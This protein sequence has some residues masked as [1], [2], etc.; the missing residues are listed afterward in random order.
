[1]YYI[2]DTSVWVAY[3]L[4]Q[5]SCHLRAKSIIAKVIS[6]NKSDFAKNLFM[7]AE[8][9]IETVNTIKRQSNKS[10]AKEFLV[11]VDTA[12][13]ISTMPMNVADCFEKASTWYLEQEGS[14]SMN[15]LLLVSMA[16]FHDIELLTFDKKLYSFY[17]A[18]LNDMI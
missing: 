10:V 18:K 12:S 2:L 3:F 14:L 1:M 16:I 15:D 7:P 4:E 11:F 6:E 13:Q 5:D 9:I 17:K 8:I